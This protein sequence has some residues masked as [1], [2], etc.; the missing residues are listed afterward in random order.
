VIERDGVLGVSMDVIML[1]EGFVRGV[2]VPTES[3]ERAVDQMEHVVKLAGG[4]IRHVGLGTDLDGGYGFEQTPSDL[5]R[6]RDLQRLIG[7]M[8]RRGFPDSDIEA[9]F[10]GNWMRFFEETLPA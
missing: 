7:I 10:F 5:N 2:S 9:V 1:Q 8:Q 4:S 3:L 6:Y